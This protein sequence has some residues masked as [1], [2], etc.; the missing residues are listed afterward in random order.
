M[1]NFAVLQ[2][3]VLRPVFFL[4]LICQVLSAA[5]QR[6]VTSN[7]FLLLIKRPSLNAKCD[8][9][10]PSAGEKHNVCLSH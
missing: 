10:N 9:L 4:S 3:D 1:V 6:L 8:Q 2:Q 7:P 5:Y